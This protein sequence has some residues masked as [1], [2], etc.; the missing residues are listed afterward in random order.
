[1]RSLAGPLGRRRQEIKS[2]IGASVERV[3]SGTKQVEAAGATMTEIVASV[4]RV[5]DII[6]EISAAAREQSERIGQVKRPS[7]SSTR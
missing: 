2:L 6:G 4:Q 5:T 1:M 3:E 7:S